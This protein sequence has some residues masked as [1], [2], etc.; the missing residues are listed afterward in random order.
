MYEALV[1]NKTTAAHISEYAREMLLNGGKLE[2]QS[3]EFLSGA[4]I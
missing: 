3:P 4:N 2:V 1:E